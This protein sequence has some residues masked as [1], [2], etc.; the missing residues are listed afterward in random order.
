MFASQPMFLGSLTARSPGHGSTPA[1][2]RPW[3]A[4]LVIAALLALAPHAA[5]AIAPT[6]TDAAKI[7]A[8]VEDRETGDKGQMRMQMT[9]KDSAGR[10]RTRVVRSRTMKFKGGT[11]QLMLFESP[12]DVR[13]TALL[14]VDYDDGAKDDD[15]W[16]YLP[17]LR[18]STRISSSDKSG[19]FMGS[20][21]TYAD[22]TKKDP[23]NY[24]YKVVKQDVKA[25]GEA[26]WLIESR[27]KTAKEQ[28]ETGYLKTLVWISKS[29]LLPVQVK[30]WVKEGKKLKYTKFGQ[31]KQVAGIWIPHRIAVRTVR[32]KK[33]VSTTRLSFLSYKLNDPSVK[34]SDFTQRRLEKGL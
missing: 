30:A 12:A 23:K 2:A 17:S 21:L 15:Q 4:S 14:S 6:E 34:A 27:P 3:A 13:N 19:A 16:L 26:C 18:K 11:K 24:T 5:Y 9:I 29:K 20:D 22:M 25:G 1:S 32:A 28:R 33:V 31:I 8:A 7:M 10:S